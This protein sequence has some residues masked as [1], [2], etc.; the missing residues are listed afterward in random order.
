MQPV[1]EQSHSMT[2]GIPVPLSVL[3]LELRFQADDLA[4]P[5]ARQAAAGRA[6]FLGS[7]W[8]GALG[9]ALRRGAC[10]T[11]ARTCQGCR[12]TNDCHYHYLFETSPPAESVMSWRVT[13]APHPFVLRLP[14]PNDKH[15]EPDAAKRECRVG[16]T[17]FGRAD[18]YLPQLVIGLQQAALSGI[19]PG[20]SRWRYLETRDLAT[21]ATVH[22]RDS[23]F[24][25]V[26]SRAIE[27]PQCPS[28]VRIELL[29]PLRIRRENDLATPESF[30]F[31]G[32]V[33]ALLRRL[34]QLCAFHEGSTFDVD[35][36]G[37]IAAAR[38][39]EPR[40]QSL[41]WADWTRYSSRQG[42][43]MKM[44]GLLGSFVLD[45]RAIEKFWPYLVVGQATLVGKGTSFG[46]G[47][48]Q[49]ESL[50]SAM[51]AVPDGTVP[52]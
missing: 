31:G 25:S 35:F 49:I 27:V 10:V 37:L 19:G 48:Y 41:R 20:R 44:G 4:A 29:S 17:I 45:G 32:M 36:R 52:A 50:R 3:Q 40:L 26:V 42:T 6:E 43:A 46:L 33:S 13:T 28:E 15:A 11:G 30:E 22:S 5:S 7:A 39:V 21:G 23:A 8:R 16:L 2:H 47:Q 9:H 14:W 18:R 38:M 12:Y 34:S 24:A 1:P 51:P